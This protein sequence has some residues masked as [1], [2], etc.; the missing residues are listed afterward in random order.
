M[1]LSLEE[2]TWE[3]WSDIKQTFNL[4][5]KVFFQGPRDDTDGG[6]NGPCNTNN[7]LM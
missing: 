4:K 7:Q 6:A 1:R 2:A 3:S 5:H